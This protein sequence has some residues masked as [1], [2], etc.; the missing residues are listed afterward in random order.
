MAFLD[1]ACTEDRT[2]SAGALGV[3][4]LLKAMQGRAEPIM[5]SL[6][7]LLKNLNQAKGYK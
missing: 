1:R 4:Y 7:I 2:Q 5:G 6:Y 3:Q